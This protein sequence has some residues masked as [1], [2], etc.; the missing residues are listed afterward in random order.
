MLIQL[1]PILP[2][3][4]PLGKCFAHFLLD[5]GEEL[6]LYWIVFQD[7]T[8]ECWTWNNKEIKMQPNRT[9]GTQQ[10]QCK[11]ALHSINIRLK[12]EK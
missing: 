10:D 5:Y 11:T 7:D 2:L 3:I 6:D 9:L 1:S 4:S 12:D 8:G